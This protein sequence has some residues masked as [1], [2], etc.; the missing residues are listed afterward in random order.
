MTNLNLNTVT[1]R[2]CKRIADKYGADYMKEVAKLDVWTPKLLSDNWFKSLEFWFN[3]SFFRGR[4]DRISE[5]FMNKAV[6]TIKRIG[7]DHLFDIS[8]KSF[9]SAL[10]GAGVNNHIDRKMVIQTVR[11][12]Q[13][14]DNYNLVTYCLKA[15]KQNRTI[16]VFDELKTIYGIG[17]KLASLFLRDICFVYKTEP[18]DKDQLICLQPV[19]TWVRQVAVRLGL[20]ECTEDKNE[21]RV[22]EPIVSY[23]LQN[24][25]SPT[26]FNA[27]AWYVG[28]QSFTLL[29]ELL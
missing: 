16:E 29:L 4:K 2:K 3:K 18:S 21:I 20:P 6:L 8:D 13:K 28:S 5:N 14:I 10:A 19:D 17:P 15:I 24:N 1:I 9:E 25:I 11:F 22:V 23:C 26:M 27:G 12:I 7:K